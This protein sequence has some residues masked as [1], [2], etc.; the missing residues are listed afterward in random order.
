MNYTTHT[1]KCLVNTCLGRLG[2]RIEKV[3]EVGEN[4]VDV[5]GL[6]LR[7][8][9]LQTKEEFFFVQV[10]AHN[11]VDDD[12]MYEFVVRY[13]LSGILIEPQPLVFVELKENYASER[14]LI[15]EN[16]AISHKDGEAQMYCARA[17]N[18]EPA[19]FLTT[20]RREVL[21]SRIGRRSEIEQIN[22]AG[23]TF[24]TLFA[25]HLIHRVDLLQ[26]DVEGFDC[27][28]LRLFDFKAY[29]PVIVRF[30]HIN[31]SRRELAEATT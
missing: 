14:Q 5:F 7:L 2:Y 6:A 23:L 1:A 15:F 8:A 19:S 27:E 20:F 22:V 18:G 25:R 29:R 31:L 12:P 16:A 21:E 10:G 17:Q 11:G 13:H 9:M 3:A 26:I 28:I 30:E 24:R 4:P